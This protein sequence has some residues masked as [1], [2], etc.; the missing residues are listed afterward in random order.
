MSVSV[1][2]VFGRVAGANDSGE[3]IFGKD[4]VVVIPDE[5]HAADLDCCGIIVSV[6]SGSIDVWFGRLDNYSE[7]HVH[8]IRGSSF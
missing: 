7:I 8:S 3:V 1:H 6:S 5:N 4:D 2:S